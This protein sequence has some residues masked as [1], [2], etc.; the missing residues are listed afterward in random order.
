VGAR[1][2]LLLAGLTRFV[3]APAAEAGQAEIERLTGMAFAP[4]AFAE[5]V[6]GLLRDGPIREPVRL[7]PT[8]EGVALARTL[9]GA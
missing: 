5:A 4:A 2:H 9:T 3:S 7:E 6:A 1:E 8:P